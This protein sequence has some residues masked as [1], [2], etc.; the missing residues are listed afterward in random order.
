VHHTHNLQDAARAAKSAQD[1]AKDYYGRH[2][3]A[4]EFL[5]RSGEPRKMGHKWAVNGDTAFNHV[6]ALTTAFGD[7]L[8]RNLPYDLAQIAYSMADGGVPDDARWAELERVMKRRLPEVKRSLAGD[9]GKHVRALINLPESKYDLGQ[10]WQN[11][12]SWL[13]LARFIAQTT[14]TEE[15]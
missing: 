9:L 4:V 7:G 2:A 5:R 1:T 10:C 3:I 13:E 6:D 15:V 8:S 12:Q 11:A 14:E